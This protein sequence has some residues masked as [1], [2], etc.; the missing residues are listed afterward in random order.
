MDGVAL[1]V[2]HAGLKP[3]EAKIFDAYNTG[4]AMDANV[5]EG[6]LRRGMEAYTKWLSA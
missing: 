6:Y 4:S 1:W 3:A 5:P 2:E